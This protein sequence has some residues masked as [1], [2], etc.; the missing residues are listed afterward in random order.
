MLY[1]N[2]HN[3]MNM[4]YFR[5][6]FVDKKSSSLE[7]DLLKNVRSLIELQY[8]INF[9]DSSFK[10]VTKRNEVKSIDLTNITKVFMRSR[11][12]YM[13]IPEQQERYH[14]AGVEIIDI[15]ENYFSQELQ[16]WV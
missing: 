8:G 3:P 2:K 6:K 11:V 12:H 16:G 5:V 10:L 9:E 1:T 7:S 4:K 14:N 15:P 13:M